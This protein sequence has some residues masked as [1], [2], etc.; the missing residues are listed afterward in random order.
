M[1]I[2]VSQEL[3]K[4]IAE[5]EAMELAEVPKACF[6]W[7]YT[8]DGTGAIGRATVSY[9]YKEFDISVSDGIRGAY[10][11]EMDKWEFD[12][13]ETHPLDSDYEEGENN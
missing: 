1:N 10:F 3:T 11:R 12:N 5:I 8:A 7:L 2:E 4:L 9:T 13:L 6:A